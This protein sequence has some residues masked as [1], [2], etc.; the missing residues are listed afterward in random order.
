MSPMVFG[1]PIAILLSSTLSD[2]V[3]QIG[4]NGI[5]IV[6]S[7]VVVYFLAKV[8][9]SLLEQN[10]S[11]LNQIGPKIDQIQEAISNVIIKNNE[12]DTRRSLSNNKQFAEIRDSEKDIVNRLKGIQKEL[13][14]IHM[15]LESYRDLM[16][17]QQMYIDFYKEQ[18]EKGKD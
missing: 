12:A 6:I 16:E 17:K 18:L 15:T 11:T 9:S 5:M 3:K 7:A 8:L 10:K 14:A 4:D 2:I 1:H 13:N